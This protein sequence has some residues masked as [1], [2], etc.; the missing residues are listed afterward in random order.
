VDNGRDYTI[1]GNNMVGSGNGT[2]AFELSN[3]IPGSLTG[4]ILASGNTFG[5]PNFHRGVAIS[6]MRDLRIGDASVLNANF[7]LEDNSGLNQCVG[8]D[9]NSHGALYLSNVNNVTVDNVDC[10]KS[11]TGA[12]NSY[13]IVVANGA[14]NQ[15]ITIKNCKADNRYRGIYCGGGKDYTVQ[16][17]TITNSGWDGTACAL[18]FRDITAGTLTGGVLVSGNTFGNVPITANVSRAGVRFDNMRD[19]YISDG[20]INSNVK[21]EDASGLTEVGFDLNSQYVVLNLNNV[22]NSTIDNLNLSYSGTNQNGNAIRVSN[23]ASQGTV[24]IKDCTINKRRLGIYVGGGRDYT[25]TGNNLTGTGFNSNADLNNGGPAIWLNGLVKGTLDGGIAM[26]GNTFG[27]ANANGALRVDDMRGFT[28]GDAVSDDIVLEDGTSGLTN[29]GNN[30]SSSDFVLYLRQIADVTVNS[31]DLT[32]AGGTQF[33]GGIR[34]DNNNGQKNV[35]LSNNSVGNRR[36]GIYISGGSDYTVTGNTLTGSG[37]NETEPALYFNGITAGT[38]PGGLSVSANTFGG[39]NA[40]TAVRFE[41]LK[42]IVIGDASVSGRNVTL[43]DG[44]SGLSTVGNNATSNES[45]LYFS[46]LTNSSINNV[47]LTRTGGTQLGRGIY[48]ANGLSSYPFSITNCAVGNRRTGIHING[49]RNYTVQ[50]N[51]LTGSGNNFNEPA[52]YLNALTVNSSLLIN[53]NTFGGAN[54][55]TGIR[56]ENTSDLLISDGTVS[57]THIGVTTANGLGNATGYAL[58]LANLTRTKVQNMDL[59]FTTTTRTGTGIQVTTNSGATAQVEMKSLIVKNRVDGINIASGANHSV[60]CSDLSDNSDGLEIASSVTNFVCEQNSFVG[61]IGFAINSAATITAE[62]NYFGGGAPGGGANGVTGSVDA[63]PFLTSAPANCPTTLA[64][65][66]ELKGNQ[67]LIL[68]GSTTPTTVNYTDLGSVK[69]STPI[70]RTFT[71]NNPG[72][73]ALNITSISFTG[74]NAGDFSASALTPASPVPAGGSATFT[75]TFTPGAAGLRSTTLSIANNDPNNNPFTAALQGT[76]KNVLVVTKTADTNDGV[77]DADCSLREAITVANSN[78]DADVIEFNIG[79]G[80]AQTITHT[81]AFPNITQPLTIDGSSQPGFAGTPLIT[82]NSNNSFTTFTATNVTGLTIKYMDLSRPIANYDGSGIIVNNCNEVFILNN[83]LKNRFLGI[84]SNSGRDHTIQNNDLRQTGADANNPAIYLS[85][86]TARDVPGGIKMSGNLF[87]DATG[88]NRSRFG[89]RINN[90]S[91]LLIGDASVANAHIIIEDGSGMASTGTGENYCLLLNNVSNTTVDNLDLTATTYGFQGW[92]V[93]VSNTTDYGNVTIK[94]CKINNRY[95][96]VYCASGRDYTIQNNDLQKTGL[97][98]NHPSLWFQNVTPGTLPTGILASGNT[99]GDASGNNL[100]RFGIRI[101]NM[102]NLLIGDASVANAHITIED[103]SGMASTGTGENYCLYLDNVSNTTVDNLDLTATTYG[104]QGWGLVVQN[105]ASNRNVTIKNC[106]MN[107]RFSGIYCIGGKD[108]TILNNDLQNAGLDNNHPALFLSGIRPGAL[109]AGV[110]ASGN[111]FGTGTSR[112]ALRVSDMDGLVIGDAGAHIV[113][114]DASGANSMS[115]DGDNAVIYLNAVSN[116]TV[117][118]VDVSRSA[119]GRGGVGIWVENS[120]NTV[121]RNLSILNCKMQQRDMGLYINGGKDVTVT[122]NDMRYSGYYQDR[123]ALWLGNI[124]S[125]SLPGGVSLS[126][127]KFGGSSNGATS[128]SGIQFVNMRDLVM[129]DAAASGVNIVLEDNSGLNDVYGDEVSIRGVLYLNNVRNVQMTSI[130]LSKMTAGQGTSYALKVNNCINVSVLNGKGSNRYHGYYFEGGRDF[131]VTGNDLTGSG[132]QRDYPALRFSNVQ[133]GSINTTNGIT[134]SGNLF[135]GANV[136]TGLRIDNAKNLLIRN[137]SVG[138]AHIVI[139]DNSGL[140]NITLG[141]GNSEHPAIYLSTV[142]DITVDNVDASRPSGQDAGGIWVSNSITNTNITIKNCNF[143]RHRRAI[144]CTGGRDYTIQNNTL[145]NSGG[146]NDQPAIYL[147]NIQQGSLTGGILMS[148]N[149]FGGA[150][151]FGGIRFE[152]MRDLTIGDLNTG[153]N[154]KIEDNSGL[155]NMGG[156]S[157][158]NSSNY[159]LHFNNVNNATVDNVDLSRPVGATP[160]QDFTGIRIDNGAAYGPITIKDC[161]LSRHRSGISAQGGKDYTVTGNDLRGCGANSDEPALWFNGITQQDGTVPMG[162]LAHTNTFGTVNSVVSNCALRL[163]NLCGIRISD[164]TVANSH[165]KIAAAS[166]IKEVT[167]TSGNTPAVILMVNTSGMAVEKMDLEFT[168]TQTGTG[169]RFQNANASQYSF[170]IKDNILKNRRMGVY[171]ANGADYTLTGNNFQMTGAADDEPAIRIEHVAEG[172]LYGGL[173][174]SGNSF[175]GTGAAFGLKFVNM[176]NLKISDGSL[177]GTNVNLGSPSANGLYNVTTGNVLH[178]SGICNATVGMLDLSR[179]GLTR[180]G[181][182]LRMNAGMGNTIQKVLVGNRDKGIEIAGGSNSQSFTCNTLFDNNLGIDVVLGTLL[183]TTLTNN[184]MDCNGTGLRSTSTSTVA[185]SNNYWGTANGSTTSGGS[186]DTY[187]GTVTATPFLAAAPVCAQAPPDLETKGNS[188]EIVDGDITPSF[189]DYT[190][191]CAVTGQVQSRTYTLKNT[192]NGI[193]NLVGATPVTLSPASGTPFTI[194]SQPADVELLPGETTTFSIQFAPVALGTSNVTLNIASKDCRE[195]PY[196]FALKGQGCVDIQGTISGTQAICAGLSANLTVNISAGLAPFVVTLSDGSTFTVNNIGDNTV[197]VSPTAT[198][199]Y[200]IAMITDANGCCSTNTGS[201]IVTVNPLPTPTITVSETSGTTHHDGI[202]CAGAS[203]TLDAGVYAAWD[204]SDMT[205]LQT[206]SAAATGTYTV[207][208][209]DGN[210]CKGTDTQ[211]IV[212]NSNPTPTITETDNSGTPND[213]ILCAGGSATLDAGSGYSSYVWSPSGNTQTLSVSAAG[214]YTVVVTDA[215]GCTGTDDQAIAVNALPAATLSGSLLVCPGTTS[216]ILDLNITAGVAPFTV[217]LSDNSSHNVAAAGASTLTVAVAGPATNSFTITSITGADVCSNSGSGTATVVFDS[218]GEIEV[219]GN[220][221][222]I[223]DGDLIPSLNDYTDFGNV[224][225]CGNRVRTFTIHNT[226]NLTLN[227]SSITSSSSNFTIGGAPTSISAGNAATFTVTFSATATGVENATITINNSDCD[228]GVYDFGLKA[229]VIPTFSQWMQLGGDIDGEAAGD[230]SGYSVSLS[231]DGTI[232]VIGARNNDGAGANAGQARVYQYNGAAWVQLGAD[233]NGEAAGDLFG[234]SVAI[235]ADGIRI[236]AGGV[237]NNGG[238]GHVRVYEY[239]GSAWIQLGNDI[240]GEAA[241]DESGRSVSL[242]A[243]GSV[244]AIGAIW[245][246]DAGNGAGQV[247]VYQLVSGSWVKLGGDID[248]E[249][250]GDNAGFS[251]SLS[252]DGTKVAVG[253]YQNDGNGSNSGQARVYQYNGSAWLQL[254]ADINGEN[255]GDSFGTGVSLSSDGTKLAVGADQNDGAGANAGHTRV[256]QYNGSAWVQTG[257]DIDGEAAGDEFG[258][259]VSL[260]SDG[261][262]LAVGG[263]RNDGNGSNAGH[264]RVF[265]YNGSAWTQIAADINGEAAGDETGNSVSLSA[266]GSVVA[267][268]AQANNGNGTEAGHARVFAVSNQ[269]EANVQGNSTN[270]TDGDNTPSTTDHTDF[271]LVAVNGNLAR[272][273]TI[274]NAGNTTLTI[275]SITSSNGL[276]VVSGTPASVAASGSATFTVTFNPAATGVQNA[277]I[278]INNNDCDEAEYDFVVTGKGATP[279]SALNFDGIDDYI[280]TANNTTLDLS[281]QTVEFWAKPNSGGGDNDLLVGKRNYNAAGNNGIRWSIHFQNGNQGLYFYSP[282]GQA[283]WTY[284]FTPNQ[285]YHIAM[286]TDATSTKLYIDGTFISS[287]ATTINSPTNLPVIFGASGPNFE[288]FPGSLDE[289]RIWNTAR[290]CDQINQLR[291]CELTGSESGLMAYYKFNQGFAGEDNTIPPVNTLTDATANANNGTLTGFTLTGAISNWVTPGGVVTG[292]SCPAVVVPEINLQGGSPL[293]TIADGDI[294]PSTT[295]GTDFGNILY[296]GSV[297][298]TFTIQNTGNDAMTISSITSSNVK[299]VVSGAPTT[300]A[301]NGSATFT[302]TFTPAETGTHTATI[303]VNSNDCDEAAYDFA[304]TGMATF[305]VTT[306]GF[307]CAFGAIGNYYNG[308]SGPNVGITSPNGVGTGGSLDANANPVIN[309]PAGFTTGFA[310]V[311]NVCIGFNINIYSGL[312]GTGTLLATQGGDPGLRSVAFSGVAKSVT[313]GRY[314]CPL[315]GYDIMTFGST[316]I[317]TPV[318]ESLQEINLQGN[319]QTILDGDATPSTTDHTDFGNVLVNGSL[320]RTFTI[321][322]TGTADLTVSSISSS[323]NARFTVGALTPASPIPAGMSANFTVTFNP[324]AN[325]AQN[326]TITVTNDDCSEAAY[327]FVVTGTGVTPGAAL[328]FDGSDDYVNLGTSAFEFVGNYTVETWVN[329]TF[330]SSGNFALAGRIMDKGVAGGEGPTLDLF[331]GIRYITGDGTGMAFI[332]APTQVPANTWSHIAVTIDVTN[333]VAKIYYNGALVKTQALSGDVAA[334]PIYNLL[335]GATDGAGSATNF[336]NGKLDEF[337]VWN[338][339]LCQNE[340]QAQMNCELSGSESGLMIYYNFNQ[341]IAGGSNNGLNTVNDVATGSGHGGTNNGTLTNFTLSGSSSNWTAPGGVPSGVSCSAFVDPEA[342][343]RGGSPL[344]TINDGDNTPSTVDSTDFGL[345]AVNGSRART[346]TIFNTGNAALTVSSITSDN[347][348]FVVSGAPTSVAAGS[349]ASFT[350]TFTPTALG[351]QTATITINNNDCDEA[352]YNFAVTGKGATPAAALNFDGTDDFV[353]VPDAGSLDLG[354]SVTLEAWVKPESFAGYNMIIDKRDLADVS[355]NYGLT[356]TNGKPMFYFWNGGN[357]SFHIATNAIAL[358]AFTHLAATYD[359]AMVRI[360]VNGTQVYAQAETDVPPSNNQPL[361]IGRNQVTLQYFDGDIDEVRIWNTVRNCDEIGQRFNCEMSVPQPGLVAY[362]KFNQGFAAEDNTSPPVNTL[363]DATAN[364]NNGTLNG[365]ALSSATS[366]WVTPGGVTT[367]TSCPAVEAPEIDVQGNSMTILDGDTT[368]STADDTDYGIIFPTLSRNFTIHN[369]GTATLTISSITVS[370]AGNNGTFS[371]SGTPPSSIPAGSSATFTVLANPISLNLRTATINIFSNDCDEAIYNFNV[372]G[373]RQAAALAFDG[374]NDY[375]TL[376]TS[377]TLRPSTALTLEAWVRSSNWSTMPTS[378]FAGNTEGA[379]GYSLSTDLGTNTISATVYRNGVAG[380]ASFSRAGMSAGFHHIA[381]TY[382]GQLTRIYLDGNLQSTNDA[383]ANYP[384]D[385][386]TNSFILGAEA[387]AGSTPTGGYMNGQLDEVRIWN[388]ARLCAEIRGY[389][390]CELPGSEPGLVA[391]YKFNQGMANG[392]NATVTTLNDATTNAINGDLQ[393]FSLANANGTSNWTHPGGVTTGTSCTAVTYPEANV[394]GGLPLTTIADGDITPSTTDHTDFGLVTVNGSLARTFTIFNTGNAALTI[395][396]ITS[397]NGVFVVSGAPT[398]VAANGGSATFTV[399]FNPTALGIQNATITVNSND[400]DEAAYDFAVTGTGATPASALHFDGVNDNVSI[401]S[402]AALQLDQFTL[403][404]WFYPS[405][406]VNFPANPPALIAKGA[407]GNPDYFMVPMFNTRKIAAGF[408]NG[409]SFV[410]AL[411]TTDLAQN[412]W[413]HLAA[414]FDGTTLKM[415]VNGVLENTVAAAGLHPQVTTNALSLG[416]T[417]GTQ[418]VNGALDEVRIW[419][420][421]RSC[422]EIRQLR[423]CELTGS[424]GGLVAYYKFNQGFANEDNSGVTTLTDVAGGDNN[425]T[426]NGFALTGTTSNWITPGGVVTGTSCPA[427]ITYPEADLLGHDNTPLADG[428]TSTSVAQGTNLG[429]VNLGSSSAAKTFTIQNNGTAAL[430]VISIASSNPQFAITPLTPASPILAGMSAAFTITFTPTATGVQNATITINNNDCDEAVYDFAVTGTGACIPPSFSACPT[431]PLTANTVTGTCAAPV[432]YT[433]TEAGNPAPTVTYAFTGAT[434]G[435]GTGTGSG[436]SFNKGNTTVTVTATST[437]NPA[438]TCSF[439]VTVTDNEKPQITCAGPVNI[440]TT[441]GLC[442]GTTVLS[443]PTVTDNCPFGGN[444]LNFDG[445][446]DQVISANYSGTALTG[447]LT[448]E[449]WFKGSSLNGR[450]LF[451]RGFQQEFDLTLWNNQLDYYHGNGATWVDLIFSYTFSNNT[452]Y[453]VAVVRNAS[454]QTVSLYVNGVFQQTLTYGTPLPV[455]QTAAFR[456]GHRAA[457]QFFLGSMDEVRVWTVART[458]AQIAGNWNK[459]LAAQPGLFALYHLNEGVANGNNAGTTTAADASGNA[460]DGTLTNF[461]LSGTTSNW[462]IGAFGGV[463]NNAPATFPKGNTTVTWT[464][465]D[466]SGNTET[467]QQTVTV[468][469][470]EVPVLT[471]PAANIPLNVIATTCAANYTIASPITDNCTGAT[472][473]YTLS[474]ATTAATSSAIASGTSSG[475][476]SFNKGVTTV[477]L[478]GVD[479]ANNAAVQKTFTVTVTDNEAPNVTACFGTNISAFGQATGN[480]FTTPANSV[481]QS[482]TAPVTGVITSIQIQ[483]SGGASGLILQVGNG[484]SCGGTILGS[485]TFN[486][487]GGFQTITFDTPIPVTGGVMYNF[488][489]L[490]NHSAG[491]ATVGSY[492]GGQMY[493]NGC[494]GSP[495]LPNSDLVF[496]VNMNY[497]PPISIN[498]APGTCAQTYAIPAPT[499]SD[500]CTGPL[501]WN[502]TFSG[503]VNGNPANL[504]GLADGS[505]TGMIS[506]S[507]GTTNVVLNGVDANGIVSTTTCPFTVTVVD[508]E[509]PTLSGCPT[510][511]SFNVIATT[512]AADYAIPAPTLMDNCAGPLT[513]NAAFSGNTNGNPTNLTGLANGAASSSISFN[514]GTTT[515]TLTATDA[516]NNTSTVTCS[517][518]VTVVDNEKPQITCTGNITQN[519]N[520]G[521]CV[522]TVTVPSPTATDNCSPTNTTNGLNFDGSDDFVTVPS[523]PFTSYTIETW[524]KFTGTSTLSQSVIYFTNGNTANFSQEILTDN[525]GHF[526]HYLWDGSARYV[527][528]TTVAALNTWYHVAIVAT[529]SGF[530]RLYVN[531]VE[532]GTPVSIG[533]MQVAGDQL[534][535]GKASIGLSYLKGTL[536]EV[537]IWNQVRS[538]AQIQTSMNAQLAGNEMGLY[539]YFRFNEGIADGDNTALTSILATTGPNGTPVNMTLNGPTSNFVSGK[540]GIP[541]APTM[542]NSFNGTSNASGD[543]PKGTTTVI[544]TATDANNNTQTCQQTV[545]VTDNELPTLACANQSLNTAP[546]LCTQTYTITDPITDNCSGATWGYSATGASTLS[547]SGIAD[548]VNSAVLTFNKGVTTV[549]LSGSDAASNAATTCSFTITVT[550]NQAPTISCPAAVTVCSNPYSNTY[551]GAGA[552]D[553]IVTDNCSTLSNVTYLFSGATTGTGSGTASGKTFNLNNTTIRYTVTDAYGAGTAS[554]TVLLVVRKSPWPYW[555]PGSLST[556]TGNYN[557]APLVKDY[558]AASKQYKIYLGTPS[559]SP[560]CVLNATN[561]VLNAGQTCNVTHSTPGLYQYF[562]VAVNDYATGLDCE[563]TSVAL[564]VTVT[565]PGQTNEG[566][567]TLA[568]KEARRTAPV[569]YPNPTD[570]LLNV[571]FADGET[572]GLRMMLYDT[573]GRLVLE[574]SGARQP[575]LPSVAGAT[576]QFDLSQLPSGVYLFRLVAGEQQYTGRV[577]KVE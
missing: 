572:D 88:N 319:G 460:K 224:D 10:S 167:G 454:A 335:L 371:I 170:S 130:D 205:H 79:G 518:V 560:V 185:A 548:G 410:I 265:R 501:T 542:T 236:A 473:T 25:L 528:G 457:G 499:L 91:N 554:C 203:A 115:T 257:A 261:T 446:D 72:G 293:T 266:D 158:G 532:E 331:G 269:P 318:A 368:P 445:N 71:I 405:T 300:V 468:T 536:D 103:G 226:G 491:W 485:K 428:A 175:G 242:S 228:E 369:T 527:T 363:T 472:W 97:D 396:S 151:S 435:S 509:K 117:N 109:P 211:V 177:S 515:V 56:V 8:G 404:T 197:T 303:T 531:G 274:F 78:A 114:E 58:Y 22:S 535:F 120:G 186:G 461:A 191:Y 323:N 291:N 108:Y 21:L 359:G 57:G 27:G 476:V 500:N 136:R 304:V 320:Q 492:P 443:A 284:T 220:G 332:T 372:Q 398:T 200:T 346:F 276:F 336:F 134:A 256:F 11:T 35:T 409:A 370:G 414:T 568:N 69:T 82:V 34:V 373:G 388:I 550:D 434:T 412:T 513:W 66:L 348:K 442:T 391:Y 381:M 537:R 351:T 6:N 415:Y 506:F 139:E 13:G 384:I 131:V 538:Q 322:N 448:L 495:A 36:T 202:L 289:V 337:R 60:K 295:D 544:W 171:I 576:Q 76:G 275:T 475:V 251:V 429:N 231:G 199:T 53:N 50:N 422:E 208:V 207:T 2:P 241:G 347:V 104:Y 569:L 299:Y 496:T 51:T 315:N 84:Q 477:T 17:N 229:T 493:Y 392:P 245:N 334:N 267:A 354:T 249:A 483:L 144:Y 90:M 403:E 67:N 172:N 49:G 543:Y 162:I 364:A 439:T 125:I 219:K 141:D 239:N 505:P 430:S 74:G 70:T 451:G 290:T 95:T 567:I 345:V 557:L 423:N 344:T 393:N 432:N 156:N 397:N 302:V 474:G 187:T 411:S 30:A 93:V 561:G 343:V 273:F 201:A 546:G 481:Y 533:T 4:G 73:V 96:G 255:A 317:G 213:N 280:T 89:V 512:C 463:T 575:Q 263:R 24:T 240:D 92:G 221:V 514:K 272:T 206:I 389:R 215:N 142:S 325:G 121:Y 204:W 253:A 450:T 566:E 431:G 190:Q 316:T 458:P 416:L 135:G 357:V 75:I 489:I 556:P 182:G 192:G 127:N 43:E 52:L 356:L 259:S 312:D 45:V 327:D 516:A 113:V 394:Q 408:W 26:S 301:G 248:G 188:V 562:V 329:A 285:W 106:K 128:N 540:L 419:N 484:I 283:V 427:S 194:T 305:P 455:A 358:N 349:S 401:P 132:N 160:A 355:A 547:G 379:A 338:R 479:A 314:S 28:I 573:D 539:R 217:V 235:S 184:I 424:E 48:V 360:F 286:V 292:T 511:Q 400:C 65:Y 143:N 258:Y 444:G 421:A 541:V 350:V 230:N 140:N 19:L 565:G 111:F 420:V 183:S 313:L 145:L 459:E 570:G 55:N 308:G 40:N 281:T 85:S 15:G 250:A 309:V 386:T 173:S 278:T 116:L 510:N 552:L 559:G 29:V 195:N 380:V 340:I 157:G 126:G 464:A 362:Y 178:L 59:S 279:A 503:N 311:G 407:G 38:L 534:V 86:L 37:L 471:V 452:W 390:S 494:P 62:N 437:C 246:D 553:P 174:I 522:A 33:G 31:L 526:Q 385:Y 268:G 196:N 382:D 105:S 238:A 486:G 14:N 161:N 549:V 525:A 99:F 462:G 523:A 449:C 361:S 453:H 42:D 563:F 277:T 133:P 321:Q 571:R 467:C 155:N 530:M 264:V 149:T 223:L 168:G 470:N 469:D 478:N 227:I 237:L 137:T 574:S 395:T 271:G 465:T 5:T 80:G 244:V 12:G 20:S 44:S 210:G 153:G 165:I 18:D 252:A 417:N 482:F 64:A 146:A 558:R 438:A 296:S 524:V 508:N 376:G 112:T 270:I 222:A 119:S 81:T 353:S 16:N 198:T 488:G 77:C 234:Y 333:L 150:L 352:V 365:F 232:M 32:R 324:I 326:A 418:Y 521:A 98:V 212:V 466:A 330:G 440:N 107:N 577:V 519:T 181:V 243:D 504:T 159:V 68:N 436:S 1:T 46:N 166:G 529:N 233:I 129:A 123:P 39:T 63:T 441:A 447:D 433:V 102:S 23:G 163:D 180:Q 61:N 118:D 94:T 262:K 456:I 54:F 490:G 555:Q 310:V 551:V 307:D 339:A 487:V 480:S 507:K 426:L 297:V 377:S 152:N 47:D 179:A 247:R 193:M 216:A 87:G 100:S 218:P 387:G 209:T 214:T 399:T 287:K 3:I 138:G 545:T 147:Q 122:N 7:V 497:V 254:G 341:G 502:A 110:V 402:T 425:G 225:L 406:A 306:I 154:V 9:Y 260:S 298:R 176:S 83:V 564:P 383:G 378:T 124:Q 41:S 288:V 342:D 375:V 169:I 367:G 164:G 413:Y 294:T 282:A 517:F 498:V 374:T 148:G 366:N 189:D 328:T 101:S 520:V